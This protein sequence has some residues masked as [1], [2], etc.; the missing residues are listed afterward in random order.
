MHAALIFKEQAKIKEL[1]SREKVL[2][3]T[4]YS[5]LHIEGYDMFC[6]KK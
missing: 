6:Y 3:K 4:H 2:A 1:G 5:I